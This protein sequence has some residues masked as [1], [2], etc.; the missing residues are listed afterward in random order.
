MNTRA[1]HRIVA[2]T[3]VHSALEGAEGLLSH[4]NRLRPGHFL[5]IN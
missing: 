2:T 1:L 4:L 3:D 5:I